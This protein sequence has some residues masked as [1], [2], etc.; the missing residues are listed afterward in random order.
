MFDSLDAGSR[1][2]FENDFLST[3]NFFENSED[4]W[5]C[6]INSVFVFLGCFGLPSLFSRFIAMKDKKQITPGKKTLRDPF[7]ILY[8][9]CHCDRFVFK[10]VCR[11]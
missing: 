8:S 3:L 6:I 9:S 2:L 1:F 4:L 5:V 10:A 11:F 7:C